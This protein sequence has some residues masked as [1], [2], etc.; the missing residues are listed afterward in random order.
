MKENCDICS[1]IIEEEAHYCEISD[2]PYKNND[3]KR[4][5]LTTMESLKPGDVFC[6][7]SGPDQF[8]KMPLPPVHIYGHKIFCSC[9]ASPVGV[10]VPRPY[11]GKTD[12]VFLYRDQQA[13][14]KVQN[15]ISEQ[16]NN[17][18]IY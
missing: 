4:Q 6:F 13:L 18:I 2:C 12:V 10:I 17:K 3:M 9:H 11:T 8:I 15:W 1:R 7:E 5:T 14:R 16:I